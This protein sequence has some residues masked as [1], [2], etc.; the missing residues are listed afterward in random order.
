LKVPAHVPVERIEIAI[1][2]EPK[3]FSR[4]ATVKAAAVPAAPLRTDEEPP[5][6]MMT[7]GDLL[8]V[9][10]VHDGHRIDEEHLTVDAPWTSFGDAAT[11]WTVTIDNGDDAPLAI[12]AV[13]LEM[14]ERR[15]CFDAD[16]GAKYTLFYGDAA[17]TAP[18]YDYATLFAPEKIPALAQFGPE[19]ANPEYRAR[20]DARPFTEKHPGLLWAAL[21]LVVVVLG[22]VALRTAKRV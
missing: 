20:P 17:L 3:N 10:G 1:G 5:E 13:R 7:T 21:I 19:E 8:R 14:A 16:P 9:H 2:D 22:A 4:E 18:R 15:L 12:T 6:P 11:K